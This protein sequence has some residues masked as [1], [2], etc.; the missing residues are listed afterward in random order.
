MIKNRYGVILLIAILGGIYMAFMYVNPYDGVISLSQMILQLSGSRG[1]FE[2][3]FSYTELMEFV[4]RL[5]PAFIFEL[6]A[7]IMIYRNFCTASV[8]IFSRCPYRVRWYVGEICK[9]IISIAIF[10]VVL[11]ITVSIVTEFRYD[12]VLD[13]YGIEIM[14]YHYLIHT[15]WTYIMVIMV[16]ILAIYFGSSTAYAIIVSFQI[17]NVVILNIIDL[18]VRYFDGKIF[19]RHLLRWNVIAHLVVGW[20]SDSMLSEYKK[21]SSIYMDTELIESLTLFIIIGSVVTMIGGII[22][23]KHDLLVS[24]LEKGFS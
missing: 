9:M 4:M 16:N 12:I 8:Y 14:I 13:N 6:Y 11:L 22:I 21:F 18:I 7:G 1:E 20:H 5:F 24:D 19:Y 23:N 15:L 2:L 10:Y 3:G 17:L